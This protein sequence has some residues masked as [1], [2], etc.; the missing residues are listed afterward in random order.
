MA[1]VSS[2]ENPAYVDDSTAARDVL[3]RI[4]DL[5]Q[6]GSAGEA[7]GSIQMLLDEAGNRVMAAGNSM[8]RF[9]PV[10]QVVQERLLSN[11]D[12][13]QVYQ[14]IVEP[15]AKRLLDEH[16]F[17]W[18]TQS[19]FLTPSG[20]EA[21]LRVAQEQL[22]R[23]A[24][25]A[26]L[27][28]LRELESHPS[29]VERQAE[30]LALLTTLAPYLT[31]PPAAMLTRWGGVPEIVP[32]KRP[33]GL[34]PAV[35]DPVHPGRATQLDGF[36]PRP[37]TSASL[38]PFEPIE[39]D[40]EAL[41]FNNRRDSAD[42]LP[43]GW[44]LPTVAGD[45]I[46][47]NDTDHITAWDR[48]TLRQLWQVRRMEQSDENLLAQRDFRRRQSRRIEDAS[49]VTIADDRLL[50]V[51]GL[52]VGGVRQ[53]DARLH[54]LD[55]A[56]GTVYWSVSPS[57]LD[58]ALEGASIRGPAAVSEGTVV[59]ALRKW[60]R[61]RRTVSVYLVGLDLE[62]GAWRWT[63]LIGAAGAL[64]FQTAGRF[65]ERLTLDRGIVYR[66]DE[67][68]V[69]AAVEVDTGRPR[70][71]HRFEAFAL[72][73]N[74]VR[75]PWTTSG[76]I[77]RRDT[78]ITI[79]PSRNMVL[80]LDR[81][82]GEPVGSIST[83]RFAG[84]I[85]LLTTET[86]LL[87]GVGSHQIAWT[88]ISSFPNG[89]IGVSEMLLSPPIVGR[90]AVTGDD[91]IV[92]RNGLLTSIN[93]KT[94]ESRTREI[95]EPGNLIAL[96][97]QVLATDQS[98]IHS[99]MVWDVASQLLQSRL[100]RDPTNP[101]PAATLAELAYRAHRYDQ[102]VSPVDR[103]LEA[104]RRDPTIHETTRRDLFA[105]VLGMLD[106]S[107]SARPE[108]GEDADDGPRL[109]DIRLMTTLTDRLDALAETPEEMVS[110]R[111]VQ[112]SLR[113]AVRDVRGSIES[114]QSVLAD[115]LMADSFW[116]GGQLT[117]RA[118]LEATR[119]IR[120]LLAE[121][122]WSAYAD[123]EREAVAQR[124]LLGEHV[125]SARFQELAETYPFSS[126]T[127][128]Y[129]LAAA[130]SGPPDLASRR[131]DAGVRA[132]ADLDTL[133]AL[134][135]AVTGSELAGQAARSLLAT[136]RRREAQSVLEQHARL[137]A[138]RPP[139]V[140][141]EPVPIVE[142]LGDTS[143]PR[144]LRLRA[145]IGMVLDTETPPVLEQ[146]RVLVAAM[147]GARP[148]PSR[149][150]L[151]ASPSGRILRLLALDGE[152]NLGER[153]SRAAPFEPILLEMGDA[154][155]LIAWLDP[156]GLRFE[157]LDLADGQTRWE[158]QPMVPLDVL[159]GVNRGSF[160]NGFVTPIE[161]RVLSDQLLLAG[162]DRLLAVAER[163][164][165]LVTLDRQSGEVLWR[166]ETNI[167]RVYDIVLG[168]GMLVIGGT[169]PN[170]ANDWKPAL[171]TLDARTGEV[172]SRL[173]EAPGALRWM[174]IS[175]GRHLVAGLDRGLICLDLSE[176]QVR[177]MLSED[178]TRSSVDAWVFGD[179]LLLL[180]QNRSIW[181]I[182]VPSGRL[183][184]PELE[185][186]GRLTDRTGIQAELVNN[187]M[188]FTSGSGILVYDNQGELVGIDV[189]D[190]VGMLVPSQAGDA[191]TAMIDSSPIQSPDGLSS[192]LLYLMA[193]ESGRLMASYPVR[194]HATPEVVRLLDGK[195]LVSAGEATLI[196]SASPER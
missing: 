146:G 110:H 83:E 164:G 51:T 20:F 161:G 106:P 41:Q 25:E 189:F 149:G 105:S 23:A 190:T 93:L 139:T 191:I 172:T 96:D 35:I 17:A 107:S 61:E 104:I 118:D 26:S 21:A 181:R 32:M 68:G 145:R 155:A 39:A 50:A 125:D 152:G 90:V 88:D 116:R 98:Q 173:D 102:I 183:M 78:L 179:Q 31:D 113:E 159:N 194:V 182:D 59:V 144:A 3:D 131:L 134:L 30:A 27:I 6:Q 5:Q 29:F 55:R 158:S 28:T 135:D 166:G 123:F 15:E 34:D 129:W 44:A 4:D 141:G 85:Y 95:D 163:S 72:Y 67:I 19:R 73:D 60:A 154:E 74:D 112:S 100:E 133:G 174:R 75:P 45:V 63:R 38:S 77:V 52:A 10:R 49:E 124:S 22:E 47:T 185:S 143:S 65:P 111:F 58:P 70:W 132:L 86:G 43:Y 138:L 53:G 178:P 157:S 160:I 195:I 176:N 1:Q 81:I 82:T 126:L 64:P 184:R 177:W 122:G 57:L 87:A 7:V 33:P 137:F 99:Y 36:I 8:D 180:D 147:E 89:Q 94:R 171:V 169:V 97:G 156:T 167:R 18:I 54:C 114:L 127:P 150:V 187:H 42:N 193:N 69:V 2:P 188:V 12:L 108:A 62:T 121:H 142:L 120:H 136:D 103:A 101:A 140:Q 14:S 92:P 109:N 16:E 79:A 13:L 80:V 186:R 196:L 128:A 153:W 66:S 37:L 48:F 119:R 175:D 162:D 165:R 11:P 117:I 151:L 91:L 148:S 46:Y 115:R 170:Q 76:P 192:Y 71:V 84:A 130:V 56:S 9:R 40:E 24:F 168:S